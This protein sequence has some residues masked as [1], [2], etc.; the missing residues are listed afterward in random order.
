MTEKILSINVRSQFSS[1][2]KNVGTIYERVYAEA[3]N[4]RGEIEEM[5]KDDK[6]SKIGSYLGILLLHLIKQP[7]E[8]RNL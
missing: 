3:L 6:I 1:V 2:A 7:A 4:L 8:K 5:S